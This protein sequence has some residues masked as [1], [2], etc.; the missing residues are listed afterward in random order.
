[1]DLWQSNSMRVSRRNVQHHYDV[2]NVFYKL[3]LDPQM[4]Y[5]CAYFPSRSA[6][7]EEA[8]T[9]KLDYVCRKLRLQPGETVVEAGGRG[10]AL[11]LHMA[12]QYRVFVQAMHLTREASLFSL[13][14]VRRERVQ[15]QLRL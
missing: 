2:G 7:L 3:W 15:H 9:A 13:Q 11:P 6:T 4:I 10:G 14:G 1:M 5:T 8:Q 12:R